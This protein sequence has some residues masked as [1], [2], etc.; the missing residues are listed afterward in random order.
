MLVDG[1]EFKELPQLPRVGLARCDKP[2]E[3]PTILCTTRETDG[4]PDGTLLLLYITYSGPN[5][6]GKF[7]DYERERGFNLY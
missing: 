7:D 5:L 4:I 3:L 1:D 2:V 6:H